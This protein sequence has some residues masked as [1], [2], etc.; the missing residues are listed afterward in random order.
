MGGK[1][2]LVPLVALFLST[3]YLDS[4]AKGECHGLQ[5]RAAQ[6]VLPALPAPGN[7]TAAI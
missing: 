6:P 4:W 2:I 1:W 5:A 7:T 3:A